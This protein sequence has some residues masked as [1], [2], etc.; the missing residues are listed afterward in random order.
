M[1]FHLFYNRAR[2]GSADESI[3][4]MEDEEVIDGYLTK[5]VCPQD[6]SITLNLV[7]YKSIV[8]TSAEC[9]AD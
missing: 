6:D 9:V 3:Y 8:A 2:I 1:G 5:R 7:G 4:F